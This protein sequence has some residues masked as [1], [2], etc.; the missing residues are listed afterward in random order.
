MPLVDI[1]EREAP[2]LN[3]RVFKRSS[4]F[5]VLLWNRYA[6]MSTH[7]V[8]ISAKAIDRKGDQLDVIDYILDPDSRKGVGDTLQVDPNTVVCVIHEEKNNL[9]EKQNYYFTV[10]YPGTN[11]R[12]SIRVTKAGVLPDHEREDREKNVHLMLWDG[13]NQNWKK[14]HGM[15]VDGKFYPAVVMV[16]CPSCGWKGNQE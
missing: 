1:T 13:K 12:Q 8:H 2:N 9:D 10:S 5:L 6:E 3:L 15:S 14:A 11:Y 7:Q 16:P 4:K